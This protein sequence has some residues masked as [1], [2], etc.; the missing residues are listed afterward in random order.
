[1]KTFTLSLIM[2]GFISATAIGQTTYVDNG[3]SAAYTL[4]NGDS[5]Y[6]KQGTF[7]GAVNDWNKGGK[8]TV[9][10]GAT[11]KP[12]G[13]NG[14]RSK[15]II[16]GTAILPSLQTEKGFSLQNYGVITVNGTTQMN[17]GAQDW[18]NYTGGSITFNSSVALNVNGGTFTNYSDIVINGDF[19][20][21]S[22]STITNKK[23]LTISG[24]FNSSNGTVT[25]EG[26]FYAQKKITFGGG[27]VTNTC[28]VIA[29][30]GITIDN[31]VKLYN[32]GILWAT[33]S[34]NSSSFTNSG[35]IYTSDNGVIKTV[36]FTNYGKITGNGFMY[37][38]GKSTLGS[39][40]SV[41]Q[42]GTT[43]DALK[44]YTVNR[45]NTSQIFDDQW[46]SVY[47]NAK[48]A[49]IAAPDTVGTGNYS[50]SPQYVQSVILP[51]T[52]DD[53]TVTVSVTIPV[54]MWSVH[55]EEGTTFLV[56]RSFNGKDFSAIANI[57]AD[58]S[59]TSYR[60]SDNTLE[61]D[62]SGTI[63][64][65]ICATE[66]N[67][68]LKYSEIRTITLNSK[69]SGTALRGLPNPFTGS[70]T[71]E[72]QSAQKAVVTVRVSDINGQVKLMKQYAVSSG[73]NTMLVSGTSG[74]KSGIYM[75]QVLAENGGVVTGK[76]MKQ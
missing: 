38:T 16:Y 2:T 67:G 37:I 27:T 8:V 64:Y 6:I 55:F 54:L 24:N 30:N 68:Q 63:Y 56:Q 69:A 9:A 34:K 17:D 21:Y 20:L 42:N 15:Y 5:L 76:I 71:L 60:F 75:V 10:S 35:T 31:G 3:T 4:Q 1:M 33:N 40:A 52:W 22:N 13:V 45:T 43:T 53:F 32:N 51:V 49:V 25:N 18:I 39:G 72:Y 59:Q 47:A 50:C 58:I 19:N 36:S 12:S 7:T 23:N 73:K 57:P 26:M 11:F 29:D 61:N 48:Y 74:W 41:G 44:I 66:P 14:Y 65:R 70:F 62:F 46:G 28:R